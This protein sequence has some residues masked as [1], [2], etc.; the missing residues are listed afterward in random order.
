[1]SD[2]GKQGALKGKL[3]I[4][5]TI[6]VMTGMHIGASKDFAPIGAVDSP[7]IRDPFTQLPII[8]GSSLKGKIRT[9]LAKS[10][11]KGYI[12]H[13]IDKDSIVLKRLFGSSGKDGAQAARLQFYDVSMTGD[14]V[15]RFSAIETDTYI[16]EIKFEN[17]ID[18]MTAT[19]NPRQI[20]RVPAGTE[21]QFELVY[22]IEN[23]DDV[24]EDM[25][26]LADGFKLLQMDYLG[27]H[28]SRGYGRVKFSDFNV[29]IVSLHKDETLEEKAKSTEQTLQTRGSL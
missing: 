2:V 27:G 12:L 20:E 15:T 14:S 25:E 6:H 22:N 9:L 23:P 11:T 21:F 7:F 26:T 28:G 17:A 1:M 13:S 8:P 3:H 5:A 4:T 18:R 10:E 19:A 24:T 16:G 29:D